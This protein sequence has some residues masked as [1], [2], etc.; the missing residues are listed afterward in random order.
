MLR[1]GIDLLGAEAPSRIIRGS[2]SARSEVLALLKARGVTHL[3][4]KPVSEVVT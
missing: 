4:G 2:P 1:N 3:G